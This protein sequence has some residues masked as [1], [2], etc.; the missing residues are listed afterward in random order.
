[1]ITKKLLKD[2]CPIYIGCF[3]EGEIRDLNGLGLTGANYIGGGSIA[4][5]ITY[6]LSFGFFYAGVQFG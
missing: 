3:A 2:T 1:M 5:C 6:C 4:N